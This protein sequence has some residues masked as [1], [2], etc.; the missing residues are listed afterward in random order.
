MTVRFRNV[1][2]RIKNEEELFKFFEK[3]ARF[4]SEGIYY[5]AGIY[6]NDT[7]DLFEDLKKAW[8][9]NKKEYKAGSA[10]KLL[11]NIA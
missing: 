1:L 9:K 6:A 7:A 4:V 10:R 5:C 8:K 11:E 3:N 2:H